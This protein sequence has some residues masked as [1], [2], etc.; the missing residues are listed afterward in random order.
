PNLDPWRFDRRVY[1]DQVI[2]PQRARQSGADLLHCA[3][4]TVPLTASLPIVVTVHDVAWL[5]VQSHTRPYARY[6]FGKFS[7]DRYRQAS[8]IAVDSDFSRR[9]LLEVM[10][11]LDAERVRVVYPGVGSDFFTLPRT[12]G[13][14]RTILVVGTVERRKNLECIIRALPFL[15][16]AR[17]VSVGPFTPYQ[18]DCVLV[19]QALDVFD[20]VDFRG[21]VSRE[22]LLAL[23]QTC[24][25]VAV[26]SRYEG[27]GYA[28]AQALCAGVPCIVSDRSSLPEIAGDHA[29]VVPLEGVQGWVD[30]LGAALRGDDDGRA[31]ASRM[32]AI[33]RFA[34]GKSAADMA[35]TYELAL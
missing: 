20:R 27:F 13:D 35:A 28:A 10:P 29:R 9:E 8:A 24:A 16:D 31:A 26:P 23:Y 34:W 7:I 33:E 17:I 22:E 18:N 12:G 6:Y 30:A 25:V 3:S 15:D 32:L 5:R 2:L 19:A 14:R 4:G 1:W 21:Y 11:D